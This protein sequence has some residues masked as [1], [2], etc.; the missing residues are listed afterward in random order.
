VGLKRH[1]I[2]DNETQGGLSV[3]RD[4]AVALINRRLALQSLYRP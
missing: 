3:A 4:D 1:G 2:L